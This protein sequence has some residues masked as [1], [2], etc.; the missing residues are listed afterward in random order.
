M[1]AEGLNQ[2]IRS[3]T[4]MY[5]TRLPIKY[6]LILLDKPDHI[7]LESILHEKAFILE[8]FLSTFYRAWFKPSEVSGTAPLNAFGK[9]R[10]TKTVSPYVSMTFKPTYFARRNL[11]LSTHSS[12]SQLLGHFSLIL[13]LF[14]GSWNG[15]NLMNFWG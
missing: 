11:Y 12:D 6:K 9:R 14:E 3:N 8:A 4:Q 13:F 2:N 1:P 15:K 10:I 7:N 5:E